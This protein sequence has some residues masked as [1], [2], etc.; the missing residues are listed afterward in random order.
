MSYTKRTIR[1]KDADF[2]GMH[3]L[4]DANG[5]M[6]GGFGNLGEYAEK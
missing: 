6:E 1:V 3:R 2:T 4:S 5:R